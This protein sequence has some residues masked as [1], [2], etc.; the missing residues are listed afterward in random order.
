MSSEKVLDCN[1]KTFIDVY[2]FDIINLK[3]N[4]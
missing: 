3:I 2:N 4:I 1:M